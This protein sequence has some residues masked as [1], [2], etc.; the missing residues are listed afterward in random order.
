MVME[1]RDKENFLVQ[2]MSAGFE[3]AAQSFSSLVGKK[4]KVTRSQSVVIHNESSFPYFHEENG[5]LYILIT[6][7]I[8][9]FSGKSFL[10]FNQEESLE[11]F[12]AI[13]LP[14]T[15]TALKEAFLLEIDNIVSASVISELSNSLNVEVYGDVPKL[16]VKNAKELAAFIRSEIGDEVVSSMVFCSTTFQFDGKDKIHPQFIW[17]LNSKV[18]E[19]I[20]VS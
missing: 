9:D 20:A 12:K 19:T 1:L 4:V 18:F 5:E 2:V 15:N 17:N 14:S 10:I 8:G 6:Q 13:N 11:I 3:R 16:I 7:I